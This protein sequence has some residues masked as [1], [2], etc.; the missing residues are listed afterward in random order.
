MMFNG[1]RHSNQLAASTTAL[2]L[3]IA[4]LLVVAV[5]SDILVDDYA[6]PSTKFGYLVLTTL[7]ASVVSTIVIELAG[8]KLLPS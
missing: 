2:L 4:V 8:I 3:I 1:L 6:H 7:F 5:A